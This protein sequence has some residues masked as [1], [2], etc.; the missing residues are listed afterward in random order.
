[1]KPNVEIDP[2]FLVNVPFFLSVSLSHH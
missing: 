2:G 1:M